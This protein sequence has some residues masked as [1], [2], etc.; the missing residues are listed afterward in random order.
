MDHVIL[1]IHIQDRVNQ[2]PDIQKIFTQY[3]CQI[4][5]RLGIHD[6]D[7]NACSPSGIILLDTIGEAG[8]I[9]QLMETVNQMDGVEIQKMVFAH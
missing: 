3:G 4:K 6:V 9:D 8:K 1:G 7:K 5:T 2:V